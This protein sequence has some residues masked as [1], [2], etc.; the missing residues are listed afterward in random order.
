M[1]SQKETGLLM[2]RWLRPLII[3]LAVGIVCCT[4]LLLA[5]AAVVGSVDI[6]RAAT[7]PLAVAAA[8]SPV[9]AE[10]VAA[11]AAGNRQAPHISVFSI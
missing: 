2:Q 5:M 1:G 8:A 3:G 6:P 10:A 4:L 9:G 7:T 11:G